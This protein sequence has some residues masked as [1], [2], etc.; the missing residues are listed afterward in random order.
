MGLYS[1]DAA[2][3]LRVGVYDHLLVPATSTNLQRTRMLVGRLTTT[4]TSDR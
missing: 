2:G 4:F 3:L 1:E